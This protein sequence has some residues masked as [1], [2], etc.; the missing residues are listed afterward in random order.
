M[1][2]AQESRSLS[3]YMKAKLGITAV[4]FARMSGLNLRN[5]YNQWD[6]EKGRKTI[7]DAVFR[8]Y[9]TRFESL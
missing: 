5:L 2:E 6:T 4:E 7:Q 1:K 9:V 8:Y 3:E